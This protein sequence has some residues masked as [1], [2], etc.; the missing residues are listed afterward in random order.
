MGGLSRLFAS[1]QHFLSSLL[2]GLGNLHA[3][4]HAGNL[5]GS[6]RALNK[7]QFARG[8]LVVHRLTDHDV[9]VR[10]ARQRELDA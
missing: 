8:T 7:A 3:I 1:P 2:G 5:F 6:G 9:I 10:P 4:D